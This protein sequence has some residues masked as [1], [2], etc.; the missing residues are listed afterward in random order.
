MK[1]T[2]HVVV[3]QSGWV[4][5]GDIEPINSTPPGYAITNGSVIEK[6]GTTAGL[7][8]IAIAG[9]T[10]NTVLREF[11]EGFIPTSSVLFTIKC[12]K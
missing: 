8:E 3:I 10:K 12:R 5:I 9:P 6:W 1:P 4:V 2:K 7:G 11:G